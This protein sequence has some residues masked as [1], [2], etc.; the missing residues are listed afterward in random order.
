MEAYI[1]VEIHAVLKLN[2]LNA[3]I[4][5]KTSEIRFRAGLS[6]YQLNEK[7]HRYSINKGM[8]S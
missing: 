3:G 6:N 5:Q 4:T 1:L 7:K 8:C 2:L